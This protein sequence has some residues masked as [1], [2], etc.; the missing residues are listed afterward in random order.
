MVEVDKLTK[1]DPFILVKLTHKEMNIEKTLHER[2]CYVSW[3][4]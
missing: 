3:D 1:F 2:D 4:T